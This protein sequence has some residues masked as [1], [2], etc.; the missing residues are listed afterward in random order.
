[1]S[2]RDKLYKL[3]NDKATMRDLIDRVCEQQLEM[4]E[5]SEVTQEDLQEE[6][7]LKRVEEAENSE[8]ST[9]VCKGD[10]RFEGFN[11]GHKA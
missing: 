7:L 4:V 5:L 1:M 10:E 8:N 6:S 9:I 2:T 11:N 3:L